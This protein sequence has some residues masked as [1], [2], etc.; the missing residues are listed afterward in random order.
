[1]FSRVEKGIAMSAL[2]A[3]AVAAEGHPTP[4]LS[5]GREA[6][7]QGNAAFRA[8]Q[9]A[10]EEADRP[11]RA[12]QG[13]IAEAVRA[14]AERD[15]HRAA[16]QQRVWDWHLG[17]CVG[18]RPAP[19]HEQVCAER[20]AETARA[21]A[22]AAEK[23][24]PAYLASR[25]AALAALNAAAAQRDACL[26]AAA[27]DAVRE[28]VDAEL[29]PAIEAVL[30]VERRPLGLRHALFLRAN[31]ASGAIPAAGGAVGAIIDL[32]RAAKSEVGVEQD[33]AGGE[34][35]LNRLAADPAAKL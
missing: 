18:E 15:V 12:A 27:L 8:A 11:V 30:L 21:D 17:G 14:E 24:L 4:P 34:E 10:L 19:T 32:I 35:F 7:R 16:H 29:R 26:V 33:N 1:M 25:A 2:P 31:A 9:A 23:A 28:V 13:V 20:A 6:L 22:D 5:P 3:T